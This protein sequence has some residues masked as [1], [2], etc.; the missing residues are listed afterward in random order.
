MAQAQKKKRWRPPC[1]EASRAAALGPDPLEIFSRCWPCFET[2]PLPTSADWLGKGSAGEKDRAGQS[3][4]Q[5][6]RPGPHRSF[7]TARSKTIVLVPLGDVSGA[8][9]PEALLASLRATYFGLE[10][11]LSTR[12]LK[13]KELASLEFDDYGGCGY[14]SQ[15]MTQSVHDLLST[16]KPREAFAIV[17]YTMH[18]LTKP[19][20]NFVFGEADSSKLTG[21]FS[22]ARYRDGSPDDTLFLR[23]CTMV[24]CHEVGHLFGIKHCVY[25]KC[26]M[27]GSNSL[28]E[29]E[30]RPFGL[31]PIDLAKFADT[32]QRSN[33]MPKADAARAAFLR[34]REE[35]I[36]SFFGAWDLHD[37]AAL[38]RQR[39]SL[40]RGSLTTPAKDGASAEDAG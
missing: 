36:A 1:D 34:E 7:P 25:A 30:D 11:E 4:K 24:L 10:V 40:M 37:D 29:A 8:P 2:L 19:E 16:I 22:F 17:A 33:L 6:A 38:S 15:L 31:C 12:K 20:F 5:F 14:G 3:F 39:L 21:V 28:E 13:K 9:P 18:D 23:R 26:L 35:A 27:N 32:L